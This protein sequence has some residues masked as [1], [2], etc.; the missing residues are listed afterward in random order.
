MNNSEINLPNFYT[1]MDSSIRYDRRLLENEVSLYSELVVLA[2][3]RGFC[4]ATNRY[5]SKLRNISTRTVQ[6]Y[7]RHLE[8]LGYIQ[9]IFRHEIKNGLKNTTRCIY[10]KHR[11]NVQ[12]THAKKDN[13]V[14]MSVQ[15]DDTRDMQSLISC[16]PPEE[17]V[18][19]DTVVTGCHVCHGGDDTDVTRNKTSINNSLVEVE[20][21]TS[22]TV[23]TSI[24]DLFESNISKTTPEI[25]KELNK[26]FGTWSKISKNNLEASKIICYALKKSI[27][28]TSVK[29]HLAY[30]KKCLD[31]WNRSGVCTLEDIKSLEKKFNRRKESKKTA[32]NQK[33]KPQM[34]VVSTNKKSLVAT[35]EEKGRFAALFDMYP[36]KANEEKALEGYLLAVRKGVSD[37]KIKDGIAKYIKQIES[38]N[39]PVK[40]IKNADTWFNNKCWNDTYTFK[41]NTNDE[42]GKAKKGTLPD[43]AIHDE[44]M[45]Q[46]DEEIEKA[47]S[48]EEKE[49][50]HNE[51]LRKQNEFNVAQIEKRAHAAGLS[52]QEYH[53]K[54][55]QDKFEVDF[56]LHDL[57]VTGNICDFKEKP[58]DDKL[59]SEVKMSLEKDEITDEKYLELAITLVSEYES[60]YQN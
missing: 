52:V 11:S 44:L 4:F 36:R 33:F 57:E 23:L 17:D 29:N 30:T 32:N 46:Y 47:K 16:M 56:L 12:Y 13:A 19:L 51:K 50:L 37:E 55:E 15:K 7:I 20:E 10:I 48:S 18:F 34:S 6:R 40:Y 35:P 53:K 39:T 60:K 41:T 5:L 1:V 28:N 49:R 14:L 38:L 59:Y 2:K 26:L 24:L 8:K 54:I 25:Y 21:Y 31:N 22:K 27:L 43:W 3:T 9:I 45:S 58:N 42:E